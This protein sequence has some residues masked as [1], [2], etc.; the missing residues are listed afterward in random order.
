[1]EG[2]QPPVKENLHRRVQQ[3]RK[4]LLKITAIGER[5][6]LNSKY[7]RDKWGVP[8]TSQGEGLDGKLLTW[9]GN[10]GRGKAT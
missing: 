1:M 7:S 3:A 4:P 6:D 10:K 9:L 8:A 2:W 5:I